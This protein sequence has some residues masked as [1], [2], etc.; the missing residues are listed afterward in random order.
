MY[1]DIDGAYPSKEM[2]NQLL[3]C[4][5]YAFSHKKTYEGLAALITAGLK[6]DLVIA[7]PWQQMAQV[8]SL[9]R[10]TPRGMQYPTAGEVAR[11]CGITYVE[12][13]HNSDETLR[14]LRGSKCSVGVILGARILNQDLIQNFTFGIV[15]AHSGLLPQN[16]GLDCEK[17]A[18]YFG[19][20][21]ASTIHLIDSKVDR[22]TILNIEKIPVFTD[23]CFADIADRIQNASYKQLINFL[24]APALPDAVVDEDLELPNYHGRMDRET[25]NLVLASFEDYK[26]HYG[27][28]LSRWGR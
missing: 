1:K 22:G 26:S 9:I 18:V 27:E 4:F 21:Q 23:D 25:E 28:L 19:L 11:A 2:T 13:A 3:I 15:N 20:P 5:A 14:L 16:R 6:P 8:D 17:W 24:Q 7:A 12:A 10:T